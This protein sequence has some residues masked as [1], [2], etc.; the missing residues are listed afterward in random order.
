MLRWLEIIH[1]LNSIQVLT[2]AS[3]AHDSPRLIV[4]TAVSKEGEKLP[5]SDVCRGRSSQ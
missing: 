1:E 5:Q 3:P 2:H 4:D